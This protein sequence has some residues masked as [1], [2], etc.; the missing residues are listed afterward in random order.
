MGQRIAILGLGRMGSALASTLLQHGNE[1]TVW[2]RTE[3][4]TAP[5]VAAGASK[6]SDPAA[7]VADSGIVIVCVGNY[8]DAN[9]ILSICGDLPGKT[10][11]QLTTGTVAE[12]EAMQAWVEGKGGLYLDGVII[13]YPSGIGNEETL[14]V[15]AGSEAAWAE[16]EQIIRWL[17]GASIF[18]GG[19][20][21]APIALESA[22]VG[23]SLMAVMGMIQGA[24]VLEK[25]GLD[26]GA[27]AQMMPAAAPLL[28][29]SLR[30]QANAIA[31]DN[32][33][34]TEASLGTWA[35]ALNHNSDAFGEHGGVDLVQPIRDLLNEAVAAG[36]GDEEIAAAI[37]VLRRSG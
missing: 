34:G 25:A 17:G 11:I 22:M 27:Y 32:Y 19:N 20:L 21:A 7:A 12:A 1:V 30:R 14:L 28:T 9:Q 16:S 26:V 4:K 10:L 3:S 35:A 15:V 6:A 13:A 36:Y 33:S 5:L 23:P 8:D 18:A 37:K 29:E 2:N 24:Y 31:T